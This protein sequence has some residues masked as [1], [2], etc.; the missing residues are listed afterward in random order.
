M[1]ILASGDIIF[2]CPDCETVWMHQDDIGTE[3]ALTLPR[4]MERIGRTVSP[5]EFEKLGL[6]E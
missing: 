5:K 4:V 6:L 2:Y 3:R 1:R